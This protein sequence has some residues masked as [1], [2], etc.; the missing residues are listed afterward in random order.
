[1]GGKRGS[2]SNRYIVSILVLM[3]VSGAAHPA[4]AV[5]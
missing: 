1:M 5:E 4:L 3:W 2:T